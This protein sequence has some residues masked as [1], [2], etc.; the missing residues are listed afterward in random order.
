[1]VGMMIVLLPVES[2]IESVTIGV[3]VLVELLDF[4]L[5]LAV[6][7]KIAAVHSVTPEQSELVEISY[8]SFERPNVALL[9]SSECSLVE[10]EQSPIA[11]GD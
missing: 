6:V 8:A 1:M 11:A 7:E 10:T 2:V 5:L 4:V 9:P 3:G